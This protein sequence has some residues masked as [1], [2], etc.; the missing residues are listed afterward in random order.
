MK[1]FLA[2][3]LLLAVVVLAYRG[4]LRGWR[5]RTERSAAAVAEPPRTLPPPTR[6]RGPVIGPA[7]PGASLESWREVEPDDTDGD[8]GPARTEPV[9]VT[10]V[11][12]TTAG[13]WLERVT[14]YGMGRPSQATVHVHDAGVLIERPTVQDIA[15]A[16]AAIRGVELVS[17]VAGKVVGREGIVVIRWE[18][19][20]G[21]RDGPPLYADTGLYPRRRADRDRLAAAVR[22]LLDP[23]AAPPPAQP[24]ENR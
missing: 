5:R 8:R 21:D 19:Q 2:V 23:P 24:E 11:S 16:R 20:P 12:T 1:T 22:E 3:L 18:T 10:Y 14:A 7:V 4:M 6:G 15:I 13:E 17:G 9:E